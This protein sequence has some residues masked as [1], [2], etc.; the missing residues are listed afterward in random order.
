MYD[1]L[2]ATLNRKLCGKLLIY[3]FSKLVQLYC[4]YFI[5]LLLLLHYQHVIDRYFA[6]F[7]TSCRI[8]WYNTLFENDS[9][10]IPRCDLFNQR[11]L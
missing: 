1:I 3:I 5:F 7:L 4:T 8:G 6:F 10:M 11:K 2:S 9:A